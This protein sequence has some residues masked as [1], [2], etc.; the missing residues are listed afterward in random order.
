MRSHNGRTPIS[1][2]GAARLLLV[3]LAAPA[4]C[5][6]ALAAAVA[7]C[8]LAPLLALA[9]LVKRGLPA[10]AGSPRHIL[11]ERFTA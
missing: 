10:R 5:L 4:V 11:R 9:L 7:G 2:S 8:V 6:G 1:V 3:L